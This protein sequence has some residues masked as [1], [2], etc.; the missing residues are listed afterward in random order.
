MPKT[1]LLRHHRDTLKNFAREKVQ[2]T[3]AEQEEINKLRQKINKMVIS[4]ITKNFPQKDMVILKKYGCASV[5]RCIYFMV[6]DTTLT[7]QWKFP[8]E[9]KDTLPLMPIRSTRSYG[10]N[11]HDGGDELPKLIQEYE[12]LES[13]AKE[14]RN[15]RRRDY[16][17][18]IEYTR[19]YEDLLE[20]WPEAEE[21]RSRITGYQVPSV[22]SDEMIARI[23][24]D[25]EA[26]KS[27]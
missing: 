11:I 13:K 10:R 17:A 4:F 8:E 15:Q 26:R 3:K 1:R 2:I 24:A 12:K 21:V 7:V 14:D 18:L 6:P 9:M 20:I 16:F 25:Q 27:A 22:V 5:D 23:K 19:N